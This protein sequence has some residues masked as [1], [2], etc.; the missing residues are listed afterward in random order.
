MDTHLCLFN[1]EGYHR[2]YLQPPQSYVRF[3]YHEEGQLVGTCAGVLDDAV[4]DCG[5]RAPFGGIDISGDYQSPV[6]LSSLV[7]HI[8]VEARARGARKV[9]IRCRPHYTHPIESTI[10]FALLAQGFQVEC[11]ELSQGIELS[12]VQTLDEYIE[13]L[14][15]PGRRALRHAMRLGLQASFAGPDAEWAEGYRVLEENRAQRG[16]TL[17]YSLAYLHHL[18]A[19]FP[20]QI[21]MLLLRRDNA[22]VAAAL[23]YRVLPGVDYVAAWGDAGHQ[24]PYSPM[25]LLAHQV[26]G[27]ALEGGARVVDL[28][29]SSVDSVVN[30]GLV[31]FKRNVGASTGLRLDLVRDL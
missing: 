4:F 9:R 17:K 5:H 14:R 8:L 23:V 2:L 22:A 13:Q 18:R 11:M 6:K 31:Q 16:I 10:Q 29:I 24:L 27:E 20:G 19:L 12:A 1:S 30:D 25:N 21:R 26:V 15:S 7:T 28:G 3:D